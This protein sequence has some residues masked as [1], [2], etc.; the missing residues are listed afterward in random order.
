MIGWK[1]EEPPFTMG[2]PNFHS[3]ISYWHS[4]GRLSIAIKTHTLGLTRR[5]RKI[6]EKVD[7]GGVLYV[8]LYVRPLQYEYWPTLWRR[9]V[10][11]TNKSV[12]RKRDTNT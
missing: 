1:F 7:C 8:V 3:I 9:Y 6:D 2:H 4:H 12:T 10:N 5:P 11:R